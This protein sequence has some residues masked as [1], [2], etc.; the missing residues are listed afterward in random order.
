MNPGERE[1][2]VEASKPPRFSWSWL[3]YLLRWL[4]FVSIV[5]CL[6]SWVCLEVV[7]N[8]PTRG[9]EGLG[10][11]ISSYFVLLFWISTALVGTVLAIAFVTI[12]LA[13]KRRLSKVLCAAI[14]LNLLLGPALIYGIQIREYYKNVPP[15][16]RAADSE[17]AAQ[18]KEILTSTEDPARPSENATRAFTTAL[19]H[20]H[21]ESIEAIVDHFAASPGWGLSIE[22]ALCWAARG[23]H[24]ETVEKLWD[25]GMA[26]NAKVPIN[27]DRLVCLAAEGGL[28]DLLKSALQAGGD[29]NAIL[30]G[31]SALSR[32]AH[33]LRYGHRECLDVLF[34][35]GATPTSANDVSSLLSFA[36]LSDDIAQT[37]TFLQYL[38]DASFEKMPKLGSRLL[39]NVCHQYKPHQKAMLVVLLNAG[40]DPVLTVDSKS[41]ALG[42]AVS[43][44]NLEAVRLFVE[45]GAD[46]NDP[47]IGHS[48]VESARRYGY[49]DMAR[50]LIDL[51]ANVTGPK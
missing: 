30:G 42:M 9:L 17:N 38:K 47:R 3:A 31:K 27:L 37:R 32:A 46:L 45:Y 23:R 18:L 40:A 29:P 41:T 22:S 11:A 49:E 16:V 36:V 2:T 12:D 39:Q 6:L 20:N 48:L 51:G 5:L 21:Y 1:E 13:Y 28:A 24:P 35:S 15:I 4:P 50:L 33:S 7:L 26:P 10:Q 14:F 34:D 19:V 43:S 44:N 25:K 8:Q